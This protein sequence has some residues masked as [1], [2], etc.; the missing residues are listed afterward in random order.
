M[1]G[2]TSDGAAAGN[3]RP[4]TSRRIGI[5][6]ERMGSGHV[7]VEP[8]DRPGPERRDVPAS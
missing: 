6:P 2:I 7:G 4:G 1:R 8:I 5:A 3:V